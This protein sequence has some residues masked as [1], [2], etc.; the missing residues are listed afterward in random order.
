MRCPWRNVSSF[1][2]IAVL[3]AFFLPSNGLA[4]SPPII[5]AG[6]FVYAPAEADWDIQAALAGLHSPMAEFAGDVE[7]Y[8][9]MS[10]VDP[11][12]LLTALELEHGF[13][14]AH[15][16]LDRDVIVNA[17]DDVSRRLYEAFYAKVSVAGDL[18][19]MYQADAGAYALNEVL[20]SRTV[21][22]FS[23]TAGR[24]FPDFDLLD[25]SNDI[26]AA[27]V[28]P[29]GLLQ[30]PFPLGEAWQ[31]NGTHGWAGYSTPPSSIDFSRQWPACGAPSYD[32]VVVSAGEGT[33]RKPRT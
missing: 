29:A 11:R 32:E 9:L 7:I 24:L 10:S 33:L 8:A 3:A 5:S 20:G 28:P 21:S 15:S 26:G 31:F 4:A 25:R 2:A 27:V 17:L 6:Q 1:L 23:I 19:E 16:Q 13:I 30:F 18:G 12:V 14:T 22:Q